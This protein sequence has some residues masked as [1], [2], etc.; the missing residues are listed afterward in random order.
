MEILHPNN[1]TPLTLQVLVIP[2]T[3][4]CWWCFTVVWVRVQVPAYGF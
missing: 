2:T 1:N 4:H 3:K